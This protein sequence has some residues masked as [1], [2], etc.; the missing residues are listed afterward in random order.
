MK[1]QFVDFS[2]SPHSERHFQTSSELIAFLHQLQKAEPASGEL[3][4]ENGFKLTFGIDGSLA[5]A[6][7]SSTDGEPPYLVAQA[8]KPTVEETHDFI[9][10]GE[11]TEIDGKAC[12]PFDLFET[13]ASHFLTT[14]KNSP[15]V[16]WVDA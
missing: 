6:Q 5:F 7:Y 1:V 8:E 3:V 11:A 12:L 16:N 14:G 13:I 15:S 4:G 9:V 10:S 2:R